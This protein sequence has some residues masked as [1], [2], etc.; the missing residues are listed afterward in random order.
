MPP[1]PAKMNRAT[2]EFVPEL[3]TKSVDD[4]LNT[5]PVGSNVRGPALKCTTRGLETGCAL[6]SPSYSVDVPVWLLATQAVP[7]RGK[8]MP[9][10]LTRLESTFRAS[11]P[12]ES[13]TS[14][15][16]E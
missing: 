9:H 16:N 12:A 2:L 14:F 8:A 10:G 6:P 11:V 4:G 15:V 1:S 7:L 5:R 13:A 3:T